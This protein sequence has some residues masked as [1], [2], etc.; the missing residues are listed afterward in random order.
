MSNK[1][2]KLDEAFYHA[3]G[4]MSDKDWCE[5]QKNQEINQSKRKE[6]QEVKME[7]HLL[8]LI[9]ENNKIHNP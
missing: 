8:K 4:S 2:D 5:W 3:I 1:W 9:N 7:E 6:E